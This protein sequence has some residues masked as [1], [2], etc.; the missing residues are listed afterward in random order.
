MRGGLLICVGRRG[1]VNIKIVGM[2]AVTGPRSTEASTAVDGG[3]F[4]WR[5]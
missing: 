1:G 5:P 3:R 4:G 2:E